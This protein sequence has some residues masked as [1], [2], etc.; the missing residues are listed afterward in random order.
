MKRHILILASFTLFMLVVGYALFNP[1]HY[2]ETPCIHSSDLKMPDSEPYH[3]FKNKEN[4]D[5]K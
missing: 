1:H 4:C 5:V 3:G 2:T